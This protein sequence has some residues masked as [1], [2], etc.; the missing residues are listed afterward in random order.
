MS[1]RHNTCVFNGIKIIY[2]D[3]ELVNLFAGSETESDFYIYTAGT[4]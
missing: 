1:V 3:K 2:A 4:D